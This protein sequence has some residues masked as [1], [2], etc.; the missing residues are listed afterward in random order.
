MAVAVAHTSAQPPG[1]CSPTERP[2]R[3]NH[4]APSGGAGD[5]SERQGS[6]MRQRQTYVQTSARGSDDTEAGIGGATSTG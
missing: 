4:R 3:V 2:T 1:D 5:A 6:V